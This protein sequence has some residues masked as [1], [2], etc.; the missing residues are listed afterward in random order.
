MRRRIAHILIAL[1]AVVLVGIPVTIAANYLGTADT[2]NAGPVVPALIV[3][4][5]AGMGGHFSYWVEVYGRSVPLDD[6]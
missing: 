6:T 5:N 2:V 1:I 4:K 3:E